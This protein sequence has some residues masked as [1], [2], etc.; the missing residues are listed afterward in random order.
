MQGLEDQSRLDLYK[1][2][3]MVQ[4]R[5]P[6][7]K[8]KQANPIQIT[9]E[10]LIADPEIH[11]LNTIKMPFA[12]LLGD[13]EIEGYKLKRRKEFEDV[14]RRQKL[15]V[16]KWIK[17]A[18]WEMNMK[19]Y[20]RARSIF[21]RALDIHPYT[22]QLWLKYAENEMKNKFVDHARN[23]W[24]R[25]TSVMPRVELFWFKYIYMEELLHNY[26][27]ARAIFEKWMT[28]NP[29]ENAWLEYLKF[30]KR[31]N[32]EEKYRE[33]LYRYL[34]AFPT[35]RNY[36]KVAKY[37]FRRTHVAEARLL[38]ERALADLGSDNCNEYFY[39]EWAK[40]ELKMKEVER[41]REIF[42]YGLS[43]AAESS[44]LKEEYI[45]FKSNFGTGSDVEK[46]VFDKRRDS[47]RDTLRSD[48]YNLDCWFDLI[49]LE[50]SVGNQKG[51]EHICAEI[52]ELG[53]GIHDKSMWKRYEYMQIYLS[54]C[55]E[56]NFQSSD[57]AIQILE[58]AISNF[59]VDEYNFTALWLHLFKAYLRKKDLNQA[60]KTLGR[61]MGIR[62]N[63]RIVK[64]YIEL[65]TQL[66]E[67]E[68]CRQLHKRM[69]ELFTNEAESWI[70]YANF[71]KDLLEYDRVR[72]IYEKV[73]QL[74][75]IAEPE[76]LWKAY[77][78]FE[79]ETGNSDSART[80][81]KRLLELTSHVKVYVA[82]GL[83]EYDSRNFE[84]MRTIFSEANQHFRSKPELKE[85][86][87][88]LIDN[89]LQCERKI[90]DR[91]H[92]S[93][94]EKMAPRKV[95]K[96][97]KLETVDEERNVVDY[98]WEEYI[99]YIFDDET[100]GKGLKIAE[101]AHKWKKGVN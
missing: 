90:G 28:W 69:I 10:Q 97:R 84:S 19:E 92:T 50:E 51:I 54:S 81:Y 32:E 9:A 13:E 47:Y 40:F 8:N 78:D 26:N 22:I 16:G 45:T 91:E 65:E 86:R 94:V 46:I 76:K 17:Y 11:Q 95:K 100:T 23:I 99:D 36:V 39:I 56:I 67:F 4:M 34:Q 49:F 55:F 62:P 101:L 3:R 37:E 71:E 27:K 70:E 25:A 88:F 79:I 29:P 87:A 12:T 63:K 85:E 1:K 80:L 64:Y 30:E 2:S 98:K 58:T 24:E 5:L 93:R 89:W 20:R 15:F 53:N 44:K 96:Q 42:E 35:A 72:A 6:E 41:A 83:F 59:P 31:I 61:S 33:L 18:E 57:R 68:R 52:S 82:Y 77:I 14:L 66:G 43:K 48:K 38:F 21:E 60:R 73:V 75:I 74:G 7:V